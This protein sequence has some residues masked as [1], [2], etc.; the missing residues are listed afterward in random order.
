MAAAL[1]VAAALG[2]FALGTALPDPVPP[3]PAG[4][5]SP[6]PVPDVGVPLTS[7]RPVSAD[8]AE[9]WHQSCLQGAPERA[10]PRESWAQRCW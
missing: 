1:V 3:V 8:A 7:T 10:D 5:P 4:T 9:R 6:A 2:G